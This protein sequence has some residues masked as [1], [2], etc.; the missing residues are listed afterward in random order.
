MIRSRRITTIT[1]TT[2]P[3]VFGSVED[4]PRPAARHVDGGLWAL[5]QQRLTGIGGPQQER[6]PKETLAQLA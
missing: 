4:L 5:A 1:T 3:S 6:P 2:P